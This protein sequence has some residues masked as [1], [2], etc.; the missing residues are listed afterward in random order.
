MNQ[1]KNSSK[2]ISIMGGSV[3]MHKCILIDRMHI[4]THR[5]IQLVNRRQITK[6]ESGVY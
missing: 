2:A 5:I 4:E 6:Q 1:K 3:C